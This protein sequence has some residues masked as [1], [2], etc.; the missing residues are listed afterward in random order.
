M[1]FLDFFF[2]TK[3]ANPALIAAMEAYR[4]DSSDEHLL[5]LWQKF[6]KSKVLLATNP[7]AAK[8]FA[9][10]KTIRDAL[11]L[12]FSTHTNE[13]G[14]VLL[15]VYADSSSFSELV[16]SPQV[17][18]VTTGENA[19]ILASG[20]SMLGMAVNPTSSPTSEL[21][22][23]QHQIFIEKVADAIKLH[24]LATKLI[25]TNNYADAE[26][27]LKG[28]ILAAHKQSG[29]QH[30]FTAELNIE[31]GRSMRAHGKLIEAE[32]V[33]KRALAIYEATGSND[34]EVATTCE[35]L[36]WLYI[37]SQ[38]PALATPYLTRALEIFESVPGAKPDSIGRILCQLAEIKIAESG[39][40]DAESYYKK[41]SLIL[42]SKKHP[43]LAGVLNK[44][45][46]LCETTERANE[47]LTYYTRAV[48]IC[49]SFKRC[50]DT[51]LVQ[52]LHKAG[53]I[54]MAQGNRTDA[55]ALLERARLVYRNIP[56]STTPA[57]QLE[58]LLTSLANQ[59]ID[60]AA[61]AESPATTTTT[62]TSKSKFGVPGKKPAD[63][64]LLDYASV[65]S[66]SR[67]TYAPGMKSENKDNKEA[68]KTS[69]DPEEEALDKMR[70]F[71]NS[72]DSSK[73]GTMEAE[74]AQGDSSKKG[75]ADSDDEWSTAVQPKESTPASKSTTAASSSGA[76]EVTNARESGAMR[77]LRPPIDPSD[78]EGVTPES[79]FA[80]MKKPVVVKKEEGV[81][82][83]SDINRASP[84]DADRWDK[85]INERS[86]S[87]SI[88]KVDLD[89]AQAA[90]SAAAPAHDA[91]RWDKPINSRT[92][93]TYP[94]V[95]AEKAALESAQAPAAPVDDADRWNKP[96]NSRSSGTY[97]Q[98]SAEKAESASPVSPA[99]VDDEDRWNKPINS[100]SSGT[101]PQVSAEKAESPSPAPPE[102]VDEADRWNKPINSRSSGTYPQVSAKAELPPPAPVVPSHDADRWDKPIN[103]RSSGAY[104]SVDPAKA[105]SKSPPSD[106]PVLAP[107]SAEDLDVMDMDGLFSMDKAAEPTCKVPPV[108]TFNPALDKTSPVAAST[109]PASAPTSEVSSKYAAADAENAE[110]R[111]FDKGI[112][113]EISQVFNR[114]LMG[115]ASKAD[116]FDQPISARSVPETTK[117]TN[118]EESKA[119]KAPSQEVEVEAKNGLFS[120][121]IDSEISGI[122]NKSILGDLHKDTRFDTPIAGRDSDGA[123]AEE[124]NDGWS[125]STLPVQADVPAPALEVEKSA[126]AADNSN[127]RFD[128]PIAER[129]AAPPPS[130]DE[131]AEALLEE[132]SLD[133]SLND[134]F[135]SV[136]KGSAQDNSRFD[137]PI[138]ERKVEKVEPVV[139]PV[140]DPAL[141]D[142]DDL[143]SSLDE[144]FSSLLGNAK[145]KDTS[146]F[147]TPIGERKAPEPPAP[148]PAAP[149][150]SADPALFEDDL[151]SSLDDAFNS[152]LQGSN[153]KDQSRFDT[154]IGERSAAA[155]EPAPAS[156]PAPAL[157]K[158]RFDVPISE[159]VAAEV[160][161]DGGLFDDLDDSLN[162]AFNNLLGQPKSNDLARF[163]QP[164]SERLNECSGTFPKADV[165]ALPSGAAVNHERELATAKTPEELLKLL[166]QKLQD[167][168]DNAD[169][170]LR[171]GTALVQ[172]QRLD[173]AIKI[174]D[175]VTTMCPS[176]IKAW[177]CK[178]S[179]MHLKNRFE[180]AIYCFNYVLKLDPN[181]GKA[182]LRKAECLQK[183]GRADQSMAIYDRML[184]MQPK[185]VSG[186]LSK[187]KALLQQ[188]KLQ[189]A[190]E[191][192]QQVLTIDPSNEEATKATNLISA[193]LQG[194]AK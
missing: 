176:D 21:K 16:P 115:P 30:P 43:D 141:L 80:D 89:A 55:Q 172:Q 105:E 126:P 121:A 147:D 70:Q 97:P 160:K 19:F 101:H 162:D 69:L 38:R 94:Q 184:A 7:D 12:P 8:T 169:L 91:D 76:Y 45:G 193:K 182:M 22:V 112:D 166:E 145:S 78:G 129:K 35:A 186:W 123:V 165:A 164:I 17:C 31:L 68:E 119:P 181:N 61:A 191:C 63:L 84:F 170:L 168:P 18:V 108:P 74:I 59:R 11:A 3:V 130:V 111:L 124:A 86:S 53:E 77:I 151:D 148:A 137:T 104:P 50:K 146:R 6:L 114:A 2:A 71:L 99:Q 179:S 65:K 72:V 156:T 150:A 138:A 88:P 52:A 187:A 44:M 34:L 93:G 47:A 27:V 15:A 102:L 144:A 73:S 188:R 152:L 24:S 41:A 46:A 37:E 190:L 106:V 122:F 42:E 107:S 117:S 85:P 133:D 29:P 40:Q 49:D 173:E 109:P 4:S 155:P 95:S 177:Y 81:K 83:F 139:T 127:S 153:S 92:S 54:Y 56:D 174:F 158:S 62:T 194:A 140:A 9:K 39:H 51:D 36:G 1:G 171:K 125:T 10:T 48:A 175:R 13:H 82:E 5:D 87:D 185:F 143:D 75:A 159:R 178:G 79:L 128:I 132:D 67:A 120:P 135:S 96:I 110:S 100:R 161:S 25:R 180:D 183:L 26:G 33:Y 157:D 167:E 57:E 134:A 118:R 20:K 116:R 23:W 103:S 136:L 58:V 189:D 142:E 66:N 28:A 90:K 98:V 192:Y 154:P 149:A 113:L 14:D 163:D 131:A 60:E 64:P 32:W